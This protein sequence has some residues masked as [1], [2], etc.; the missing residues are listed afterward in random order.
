LVCQCL[1]VVC[2]QRCTGLGRA[3]RCRQR[4]QPQFFTTGLRIGLMPD[5]PTAPVQATAA[6]IALIQ[7]VTDKGKLLLRS[8]Q[9]QSVAFNEPQE[10]II[11]F[12]KRVAPSSKRQLLDLPQTIENIK[13]RYRQGVQN[14]IGDAP[15][16]AHAGP[17]YA[18]RVAAGTQRY[19]CGSSISVGNAREAGTMGCLVRDGAGVLYGLSNNHVSGS[20]NFAGI[21]LPILAP[22]VVDVAP[23]NIAP[24]TIGFHA[25]SLTFVA[26]SADNVDPKANLDAAIFR[27][28]QETW[29]SSFQRDVHDTP[30]LVGDLTADMVV[31]KVGRTTGHTT[32]RVTGQIYG[33]HP[34]LYSAPLYSHSSVVS[35][36]P[37]FAITGQTDVFSDGGDSGSLIT[38][39]DAAG[40]RMAVG[41]VVGGMNDGSAPG[42][43]VTI[44]L[45][46]RPILAELGVNLVSGHNI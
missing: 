41:I 34:I 24:F 16:I 12:T 4:K 13:I 19:T 3:D 44:A 32:G 42:K 15:S 7:P 23:T 28:N 31:E 20:C 1:P 10:E 21:N 40:Q 39:I 9:V 29:V 27:I 2:Y 11:V 26:G 35:F 33:A 6:E 8:K 38:S 43:K 46:I 17:T 14:P 37:V 5:G 30:T 18:V 45:P 36:E 22:G 25:R